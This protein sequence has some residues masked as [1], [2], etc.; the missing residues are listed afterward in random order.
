MTDAPTWAATL[1]EVNRTGQDPSKIVVAHLHPGE[2]SASF[3]YSLRQSIALDLQHH[4]RLVFGGGFAVIATQQGAGRLER[5]R[6]E[7]VRMFLQEHTH[8]DVLVFIDSDMG[9]DADAIEK[10]VQVID[11]DPNRYPIVGGLCFGIKPTA[12]V[13][14]AA[15]ETE[16]FPTLYRWAPAGPGHPPGFDAAYTY[17][18]DTVVEVASTGAAFLGMA[19]WALEKIGPDPFDLWTEKW[20]D[21]DGTVR[22]HPFG[23]DMSFCLRARSVGIPVHV[24][25]GAKTSHMKDVWWTEDAYRERRAPR[26]SA[27][28]VIIPVKDRLDLTR[29]VISDLMTQG[30]WT[31]VLI[32]DNGSSDPEMVEWLAAQDV[33]TVL[34]MPDAGIHEMWQEG[35][36][37]ARRRH[38]G[39]A[40]LIFLNNDL[41]LGPNFCQ[42][43]IGEMRAAPGCVVASGC[44]DGR[45]GNGVVP[46]QGI[47][48]NRYD[49]SG[50]LAG[51]AFAM[52]AEWAA[53]WKFLPD[54]RWWYGDTDLAMTIDSHPDVWQAIVC[55]ALVQHVGGGSQTE[56]PEGWDEIIEA[57]RQAFMAKWPQVTLT[58]TA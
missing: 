15:M 9:W 8:A 57:D 18:A 34:P 30:G 6:N 46:V 39:L 28:T 2:V 45:P 3:D 19:R 24:H 12:M 27:V 29:N 22:E 36:I 1:V 43:L 5:G 23:E 49:G 21:L 4:Q 13:A 55:S 17:P 40:D 51:F 11:S 26:A 58:P 53:S 54:A 10:I 42:R 44:Y 7:V 50:G 35:M 52:R 33:A 31:D 47:C 37:E 20:T 16:P 14:Q 56:H 38:G 48:A 41:R 25:T 32:M